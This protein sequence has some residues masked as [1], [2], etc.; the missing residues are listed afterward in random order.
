MT[1]F[2]LVQF[3][4]A[5]L[6]APMDDPLIAGFVEGLPPINALA[7]AQPGFVWRLETEDG[8]A[9]SIRLYDDDLIIVNM[10]VWEDVESLRA[11]VYT[12]DHRRYLARRKEWFAQIEDAY[13][14]L[15]WVPAGTIPD[16]T[17]GVRRLDHLRK[18]GP[19]PEA[20]T[21]RSTFPAPGA[22]TRP[23]PSIPAP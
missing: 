2:H 12:T 23:D 9:T 8:D 3:N 11:F 1:E 20:F 4:V 6:R 16:Q 15:W 19:T 10:S 21:L 5:R 13:L 17:E 14:V 18:H 22:T 7:D